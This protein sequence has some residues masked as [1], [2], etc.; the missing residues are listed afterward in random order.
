MSSRRKRQ[1]QDVASLDHEIARTLGR[2]IRR[3]LYCISWGFHSSNCCSGCRNWADAVTL[4]IDDR[5]PI[6]TQAM[7][8]ALTQRETTHGRA[9]KYQCQ[10]PWKQQ[11]D[12]VVNAAM[13]ECQTGF[14][15]RHFN[16]RSEE[17]VDEIIEEE[18]QHSITPNIQQETIDNE[19]EKK[20]EIEPNEHTIY[21]RKEDVPTVSVSF[22]SGGHQFNFD[23]PATHKIIE[24][25][26]N[27]KGINIYSEDIII[28]GNKYN[29]E[30]IPTT[31]K[32]CQIRV[33]KQY[34]RANESLKKLRAICIRG[35]YQ[36]A[37]EKTK[38]LLAT[39]MAGC[40]SYALSTLACAMP[41]LVY[42]FLFD[43][44]VLEFP[45]FNLKK[46]CKSF[47]S[48]SYMRGLMYKKAAACTL[49]LRSRLRGKLVFLASD[50]GKSYALSC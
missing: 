38:T 48:E 28:D 37:T 40:P 22:S 15:D 4:S 43:T 29:V 23:I 16:N 30:N 49:S 13:F 6:L 36:D 11:P 1:R 9:W 39:V 44:G 12:S 41:I 47:P 14:I 10:Q 19:E 33:F 5:D 35:R 25:P 42:A 21:N 17:L 32:V 45:R 8:S 50:K 3:V 26:A 46:Y 31:H 24:Q 34:E 7:E 2:S 27:K 18:I 20:E